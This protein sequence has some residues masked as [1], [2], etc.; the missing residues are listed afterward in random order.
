MARANGSVGWIQVGTEDPETAKHF[1]GGLFGWTFAPDP[2]GGGQYDLLTYPGADAPA[3]GIMHTG[4][5]LPKHA[6]FFVVVDDVAAASTEA[7][8][9]GGKVLTAPTTTP[10]GLVFADLLDPAGNHIGIFTP[11]PP[12]G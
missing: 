7:E 2:N 5:E 9:L 4:G 8:K 6:I 12:A 1:Y 11:P 10:T 3:G